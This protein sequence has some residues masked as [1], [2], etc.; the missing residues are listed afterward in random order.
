[1]RKIE[2]ARI[3]IPAVGPAPEK[4]RKEAMESRKEITEGGKGRFEGCPRA[5][6]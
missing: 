1:M 3:M 2:R 5:R 6:E 4:E